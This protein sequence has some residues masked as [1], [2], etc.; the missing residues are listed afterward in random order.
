MGAPLRLY[1]R[2]SAFCGA[3][4]NE[5]ELLRE[6]QNLGHVTEDIVEHPEWLLLECESEIM[7]REVQKQIAREMISPLKN[8]NSVMQL[9]MGEGKSS[10]IVPIV[11][12]ALGNGKQLVRVIVAKPQANQ[13]HQMLLSKLAGY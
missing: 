8:N 3:R 4:E 2:P 6:L 12:T 9:S 10:V 7:I 1:N 5:A 13:I 11:A